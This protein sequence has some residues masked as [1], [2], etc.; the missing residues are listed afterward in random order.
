MRNDTSRDGTGQDR[1]ISRTGWPP[2]RDAASGPAGPLE[3]LDVARR[4]N[5][6]MVTD[7]QDRRAALDR[8]QA[9]EDARRV[10]TALH[11]LGADLVCY[12]GPRSW[13]A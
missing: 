7:W 5:T 10:A 11:R 3:P 8:L 1:A 9:Q 13:A 12:Y 2:G 4:G 6:S